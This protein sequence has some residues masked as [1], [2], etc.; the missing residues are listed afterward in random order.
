MKKRKI[1]KTP[2]LVLL[3]LICLVFG[4]LHFFKGYFNKD[5][6]EDTPVVEEKTS[7]E[8]NLSFTLAGNVL[9]N[10]NMWADTR[11]S[12]SYD[13][14]PI[15]EYVNDIMKKSD[16]NFYFEQSILGGKEL[17][18]S[19][20]YNYNT[21]HELLTT[22]SNIGFNMTSLGSRHA[23]DKG[24]TGITNSIKVLNSNKF[25]YSG[26]NDTE[27]ISKD[28]IMTKNGLKVGLLSYTTE[29]DEKVNE[30]YAVNIYSAEK[31]KEDVTNLK[32][33]VDIIIVSIDW[34][35]ISSNDVTT[36]QQEIAKYLSELGVN[37]VVGDNGYSIQPVEFIDNTLVCYSLGNLLSGHTLVSSRLSTMVDFNLKV[38]KDGNNT[39]ITF[40]DINVLMNYAYN[41]NGANYK[42]IPFSKMSNEL[43]NY[44]TYYD[45]YKELLTSKNDKVKFYDIGE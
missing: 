42:I 1:K 31:V 15:F 2:F 10:S 34:S 25:T 29:T 43:T 13:F 39:K 27:S 40:E 4:V 33:D 45:N 44:K 37:I 19:L 32:K 8:Y 26:V 20:Y 3:I 35:N 14:A 11:N 36:E 5:D 12:D 22:M 28:N 6:V 38:V 9:V 21:P 16:I 24:L 30:E 18:S 23:Y 41:I 7:K 17:G